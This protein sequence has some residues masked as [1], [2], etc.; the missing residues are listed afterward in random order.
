MTCRKQQTSLLSFFKGQG[1]EEAE[2]RRG[3]PAGAACSPST[4]KETDTSGSAPIHS[5][6][7]ARVSSLGAMQSR[8]LG[9]DKKDTCTLA[10]K[11]KRKEEQ[12]PKE[13]GISIAGCEAADQKQKGHE[14]LGQKMPVAAKLEADGQW[15]HITFGQVERDA[16]ILL[17]KKN[18]KEVKEVSIPGTKRKRV[19]MQGPAQPLLTDYE[20]QRAENIQKNADFLASLGISSNILAPKKAQLSAKQ[21]Q[22][23]KKTA[24]QPP[25]PLQRSTRAQGVVLEHEPGRVAVRSAV[26]PEVALEPIHYDDST[27]RQYTCRMQGNASQDA[28][29]APSTR[30]ID[31]FQPTL[32]SYCDPS[33]TRVYALD[34]CAAKVGARGKLLAAG[35]HAGRLAVFGI[36]EAQESG[37]CERLASD[38]ARPANKGDNDSE[39]EEGIAD[40][41]LMA[42]KG[43]G[44]WISA[45]QFLTLQP[46]ENVTLLL[47]S[48]ND[49]SVVLWDLDKVRLS[50]S[51]ALLFVSMEVKVT[52]LVIFSIQWR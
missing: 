41:P 19:E 12:S 34:E 28:A 15:D 5:E 13:L 36:R 38:C 43:G 39:P 47:T 16:S 10:G 35:G 42:W 49:R 14:S 22:A 37:F 8:S 26:E 52:S 51:T 30:D 6:N 24:P 3:P 40:E 27:V 44:G 2:D 31:S 45:V 32:V 50:P 48:S 17:D 33:M 18:V 23:G 46:H 9:V 7:V 1:K 20:R 21:K 29:T 4:K 11:V 25:L